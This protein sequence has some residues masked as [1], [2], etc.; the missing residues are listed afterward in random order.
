MVATY[1]VFVLTG[2]GGKDYDD[3]FGRCSITSKETGNVQ[4]CAQKL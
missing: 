3:K 2:I 4:F 1:G